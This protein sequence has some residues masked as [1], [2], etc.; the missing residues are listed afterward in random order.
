[1]KELSI[2]EKA[3]RY[4]E[5]LKE[6]VIAHKDEDKHLK[7]ALER[8][9]PELRESEDEMIREE[10]IYHIQNCD[11]TIDEE[12]EERIIAWL[13]KQGEHKKFRDSI[14]VGDKV[15]RNEDGV[16]VNL[17]QLNR[18]AKPTAKVELKFKV[19]DLV[20]YTNHN[21]QPIYKVIY[22][23]NECY[24]CASDDATLGDK[25]IMH[26]AFD[27]PYLRLVEQKSTDKTKSKFHKGE[28]ITNG[29]YT[30]KIVE[31][32]PLYYTLQSQNG[33]TVDD[34]I[35]CM[36]EHFHLWT[37]EDAKNGDVLADEDIILIFRGIGN[38]IWDDVI[39][40]H[41]YYDCYNKDFIVQK[42]LDHWGDIKNN[43]LKPATKEQ[44]DILFQ[45]MKEAGY[46]WDAVKK[47][48]KID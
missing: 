47:L 37:I 25:A 7:A 19:G 45:K 21:K 38:T 42:D 13:E 12:T 16:L 14:Q 15:T 31:V 11:D 5:A 3:K 22:I 8:I 2:E 44:R 43:Q 1:M 26:F 24:I 9:F 33:D 40:Y 35:S 4:D 41:C 27:N 34:T 39:D 30:W 18:V 48:K 17:S 32:K 6:A 23:D 28:W 10:I 29:D 20:K 46:T 36:N